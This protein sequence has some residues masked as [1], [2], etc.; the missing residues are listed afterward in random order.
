MFL[1]HALYC[2]CLGEV[3]RIL[4]SLIISD[5]FSS[6]Y[7][8]NWKWPSSRLFSNQISAAAVFP[9]AGFGFECG[10]INMRRESIS[11]RIVKLEI[12]HAIN[13]NSAMTISICLWG[14]HNLIMT[15]SSQKYY[16][17]N[18]TT[19]YHFLPQQSDHTRPL[20]ESNTRLRV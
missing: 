1:D 19:H 9:S 8:F 18:K 17:K 3:E 2:S 13:T 4:R 16:Q 10:R 14:A 5:N 20:S 11:V 6:I 7:A 15:T 12:F